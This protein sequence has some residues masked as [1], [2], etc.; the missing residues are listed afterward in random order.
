MFNGMNFA[1]ELLFV[2]VFLLYP[3]MR[4]FNRAGIRRFRAFVLFIPVVG[5]ILC[6]LV[7]ALSTWNKLPLSG[8]KR[9]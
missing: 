8:D 5:I 7:L 4:I 1:I 2:M 9:T 3:V 6:G